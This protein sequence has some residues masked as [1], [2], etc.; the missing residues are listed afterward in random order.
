MHV[1]PCVCSSEGNLRCRYSNFIP[2][3]FLTQSLALACNS[4]NSPD[5]LTR[6]LEIHPYSPILDEEHSSWCSDFSLSAFW[7]HNSVFLVA[8][9]H[10]TD[11]HISCGFS[12]EDSSVSWLGWE[13]GEKPDFM[14]SVSL[15]N[16]VDQV[17]MRL[18]VQRSFWVVGVR[19]NF[20]LFP[21]LHRRLS[22]S[23]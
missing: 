19:S 5:W 18:G 21:I 17:G 20:K 23:T 13:S 22:I 16:V 3:G 11:G 12:K 6:V 1:Y 8:D 15:M 14:A 9:K 4:P 7:K 2:F 10:F